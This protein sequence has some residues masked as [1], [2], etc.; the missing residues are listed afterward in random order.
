MTVE[1]AICERLLANA[2]V[3]ALAADRGYLLKLPQSPTL[4]AFRVTLIS[5]PEGSHL[6]GH[7][8]LVLAR[9]Q[10]DA[11]ASEESSTDPYDAAADLAGAIATA[12]M[13]QEPFI[14]DDLELKVVEREARPV[15]YNADELREVMIPQDFMIWTK[16]LS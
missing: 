4:P 5:G 1:Q 13:G 8:A 7:G 12:L 11:I 3:I 6:R 16:V 15:I 9:V 10:V 14:S 2:G